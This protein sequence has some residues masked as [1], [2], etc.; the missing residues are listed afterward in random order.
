MSDKFEEKLK[1]LGFKFESIL[2]Y[3]CD[4]KCQDINF[5][6]IYVQYNSE[7][8]SKNIKSSEI[9]WSKRHSCEKC[10]KN[11]LE[12]ILHGGYYTNLIIF[13][14][15]KDISSEFKIKSVE[16]NPNQIYNGK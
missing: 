3:Y 5:C 1:T 15:D 8:Y 4:E 2:Q 11:V 6:T 14:N 9:L 10:L 12:M 16:L 7:Y 13:K